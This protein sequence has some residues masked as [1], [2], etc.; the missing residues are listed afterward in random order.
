MRLRRLGLFLCALAALVPPCQGQESAPVTRQTIDATKAKALAGEADSQYQMALYYRQGVPGIMEQDRA[1]AARW[2]SFAADHGS[3]KARVVIAST[4]FSQDSPEDA[5]QRALG[6][7]NEGRAQHDVPS[8][9]LLATIYERGSGVRADAGTALTILKEN[10]ALPEIANALGEI[11][12]RGGLGQAVDYSLA[13]QYFQVAAD[14]DYPEG[15][16]NVGKLYFMGRGRPKDCAKAY[17]YFKKAADLND[18]HAIYDMGLLYQQ[19]CGVAQDYAEAVR[20]FQKASDLGHLTAREVLAA[21]YAEGKGVAKDERR[22]IELY[23]SLGENGSSGALHRLAQI[24][25][26]GVGVEKNPVQAFQHELQAARQGSIQALVWLGGY[27]R[28]GMGTAPDIQASLDCF[29]KAA[30]AGNSYAKYAI[31]AI[32]DAGKHVKRDPAMAAKW[33]ADSIREDSAALRSQPSTPN[34]EKVDA[35]SFNRLGIL[36]YRGDGV[37]K[38]ISKAVELFQ[39]GAAEGSVGAMAFLGGLYEAGIG[40][41]ADITL[42]LDW[43]GKAADKGDVG[44]MFHLG[45]YHMTISK[46]YAKAIF[47]FERAGEKGHAEAF[48]RLGYMQAHGLGCAVDLKMARKSYQKADSLGFAYAKQAEA[49]R[50]VGG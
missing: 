41:P 45:T 13:M 11:Y 4:I 37:P 35:E 7:L 43:F 28:D 15:V 1:E 50:R 21:A 40:L 33:Y 23:Q 34:A 30:L 8:I 32:Y 5:R 2:L 29:K 9:V 49:L 22:A 42:A 24:H 12:F 14:K 44:S 31:G 3:Q 38:D 18:L 47:N 39:K 25:K 48:F 26:N 27:Y 46:D 6:W 19:G 10:A 20:W 17:T 36:Y 16:K